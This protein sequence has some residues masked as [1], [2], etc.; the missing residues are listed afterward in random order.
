MTPRNTLVKYWFCLLWGLGLQNITTWPCSKIS[1]LSICLLQFLQ[2]A[3][4]QPSVIWPGCTEGNDCC[5][6]KSSGNGGRRFF[7]FSFR[8][9][10]MATIEC[11]QLSSQS[12][13]FTDFR[14][15]YCVENGW[16]RLVCIC[17]RKTKIDYCFLYIA[18]DVF[19]Q[20]LENHIRFLW[21]LNKNFSQVQTAVEAAKAKR[22]V[23][24][25]NYPMGF[26]CC[27]FT[28]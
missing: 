28:A 11:F 6:H 3:V 7:S 23:L 18:I 19:H 15:D 25:W 16:N 13:L 24:R 10:R 27:Q 2:S 17:Q 5:S 8:P 26:W 1:A 14:S 22:P 12:S 9:H 4:P 21:S 20:M